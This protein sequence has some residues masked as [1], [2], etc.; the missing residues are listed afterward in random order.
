MQA[1][2]TASVSRRSSTGSGKRESHCTRITVMVGVAGCGW[3]NHIVSD[4][5]GGISPGSLLQDARIVYELDAVLT[6]RVRAERPKQRYP[7][8]AG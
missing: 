5:E 1:R 3:T 7:Q 8:S 4:A 2:V 6:C